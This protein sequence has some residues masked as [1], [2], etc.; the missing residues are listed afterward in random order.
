MCVC[1]CSSTLTNAF[2]PHFLVG[3]YKCNLMFATHSLSQVLTSGIEECIAS[4]KDV[5]HDG[6][7]RPMAHESSK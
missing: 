3:T 2:S 1:L 4:F 7:V 6:P 5:F